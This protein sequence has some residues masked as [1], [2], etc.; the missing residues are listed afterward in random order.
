MAEVIIMPRMSDTMTEGV[1][2]DWHKKVGDKV[3]PGD[4]LAEVETDKATME[5]ES[6]QEGTLLYIGVDKGAAVPVEGVIAILGEEGEDYKELLADAEAAA[7]SSNGEGSAEEAVEAA[8]APAPVEAVPTP[9]PAPA[10]A[11]APQPV[12]APAPTSN[13]RSRVSPLAKK[14]ATE[15]GIDLSQ[16]TG[17]GDDGRI[18]K[19]DIEG[20]VP[21]QAATEAAPV[22]NIP[23]VTGEEGFDEI[24][25]SQ[26]RKTIAS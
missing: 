3:E 16:V 24:Q 15:R 11:P 19:R 6:Y 7:A 20:F 17:S 26:M 22:I 2:V 4:L 14:M 9:A 25:V 21:G 8:P 12:A 23:V 18:I 1:I 10:P 13:G 5:L